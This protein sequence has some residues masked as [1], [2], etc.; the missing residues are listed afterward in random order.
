MVPALWLLRLHGP[1]LRPDRA[2]AILLADRRTVAFLD[3]A[4][5]YMT[6]P[7]WPPPRRP[8]HPGRAATVVPGGHQLRRRLLGAGTYVGNGP[9]FMVKAIAD[10]SGVRAPSF[11]GYLVYSALVLLPVCGL[12]TILFFPRG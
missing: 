2:V 1:A 6:S 7:P 5:T 9:N 4:P 12:V 11:F 3:N 8:A 10:A